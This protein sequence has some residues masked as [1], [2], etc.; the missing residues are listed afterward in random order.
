MIVLKSMKN[1]SVNTFLLNN[2][3]DSDLFLYLK[4]ERGYASLKVCFQDF[5]TESSSKH[6]QTKFHLCAEKQGKDVLQ[7]PEKYVYKSDN[8]SINQELLDGALSSSFAFHYD[9]RKFDCVEDNPTKKEQNDIFN[10]FCV[11]CNV[12][13]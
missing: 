4:F 13:Y 12:R 11:L 8:K 2:Q 7:L 9:T 10:A 6:F 5:L 1:I 3:D